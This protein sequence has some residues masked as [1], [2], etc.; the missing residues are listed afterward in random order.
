MR[1][2]QQ[3][4]QIPL[5]WFRFKESVSEQKQLEGQNPGEEK[6]RETFF[7]HTAN[8]RNTWC[9]AT[10]Y[11][12]DLMTP[13][14]VCPTCNES[15]SF[16]F[17]QSCACLCVR[18]RENTKVQHVRG[19]NAFCQQT[20]ARNWTSDTFCTGDLTLLCLWGVCLCVSDMYSVTVRGCVI[21]FR[22]ALFPAEQ[23]LTTCCLS[24][25]SS[26]P[27]PNLYL[28]DVSMIFESLLFYLTGS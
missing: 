16:L 27:Q 15:N 18:A 13:W 28:R 17:A 25:A 3:L 7:V 19:Q 14:E 26:L 22:C 21:S 9:T 12:P 8:S 2:C 6:N 10:I 1:K 11:I 20:E 5:Q 23:T 24:V 4:M